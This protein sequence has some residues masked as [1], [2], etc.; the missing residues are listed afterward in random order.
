MSYILMFHN[1]NFLWTTC[2]DIVFLISEHKMID[3]KLLKCCMYKQQETCSCNILQIAVQMRIRE[4]HIAQNLYF[5]GKLP[6]RVEKY[7]GYFSIVITWYE[8]Y[9]ARLSSTLRKRHQK[10]SFILCENENHIQNP[11]WCSYWAATKVK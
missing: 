10:C 1:T 9:G 8:R 2:T 6:K 4:L 11:I 3:V 7:L 5:S